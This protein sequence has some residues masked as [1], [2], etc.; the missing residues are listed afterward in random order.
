MRWCCAWRCGR[1]RDEKPF[2][3]RR[4][5]SPVCCTCAD[6]ESISIRTL[7][8]PFR[9]T[10][11]TEFASSPKRVSGA[12]AAADKKGS[13][14]T[15]GG[16]VG[17]HQAPPGQPRR[18][19]SR[20]SWVDAATETNLQRIAAAGTA[21][22]GGRDLPA[23]AG[24]VGVRARRGGA[25]ARPVPRRRR[26]A[27]A[28]HPAKRFALAAAFS[29]LF[30]AGAAFTAGAGDQMVH[31]VDGDAAAPEAAALTSSPEASARHRPRERRARGRPRSGARDRGGARARRRSGA[32]AAP[33]S[34]L[35][36]AA[37]A[38]EAAP[39]GRPR[40]SRPPRSI[41]RSSQ[42]W[43]PSRRPSRHPRRLPATS[44]PPRRRSRRPP[45]PAADRHRSPLRAA[46]PKPGEE[47][48]RQA[49]SRSA[50]EG[51]R[52]RDR[53]GRRAD[54]LAQP[55]PAGSDSGVRAAAPPLREAAR[56]AS[57]SA[58]APTGPPCSA[59]CGR[60]E[61]AARSR[62]R[63][64]SSTLW[65]PGWREPTP[66]RARSRSPAGRVSPT[67]LPRSPTSTASS[68]SRRS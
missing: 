40:P 42:R 12:K 49:R 55:C 33:P 53:A 56:R 15:V 61:S 39:A 14:G 7:R 64:A 2:S 60:R 58:T 59:S 21:G 16:A 67:A 44:S 41:R 22:H 34:R 50:G 27:A 6:Q 11:C 54:D 65:P 29:T 37:P 38:P 35:R 57:R 24:R 45:L 43:R 63:L 32:E 13:D 51:S 23:Q 8:S 68:A 9:G 28:R 18:P 62:H 20:R 48:G 26:A 52:G 1:T 30:F 25:G 5:A 47:V 46:K 4:A 36:E 19:T 3:H 10:S 66:G 31:L 17:N